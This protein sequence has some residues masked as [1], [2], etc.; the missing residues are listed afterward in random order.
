MKLSI[1]HE[2]HWQVPKKKNGKKD[3]SILLHGTKDRNRF[4]K[5]MKM[6]NNSREIEY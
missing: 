6:G 3:Y 5:A 1:L 2:G 4:L